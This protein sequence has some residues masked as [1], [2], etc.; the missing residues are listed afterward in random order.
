VPILRWRCAHGEAPA[1]TLACPHNGRLAIAPL[2]DSVDSN[3]IRIKGEGAIESF[4]EGPAIVKRVMFTPGITLKHN[5]PRL[6]LLTG[7]DRIITSP[8]VGLYACAGGDAWYE[9]HFSATGDGE[10]SRRIDELEQRLAALE[11]VIEH[12][13]K[14]RQR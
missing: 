12:A 11:S 1:V 9:I 14:E 5:P 8:A 13:I 2:D 6:E 10:P 3:A 4:G 7:H